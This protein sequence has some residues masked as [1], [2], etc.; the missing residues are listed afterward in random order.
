MEQPSN[1]ELA[2]L[3]EEL[4]QLQESSDQLRLDLT[5]KLAQQE[6]RQKARDPNILSALRTL[7]TD[8]AGYSQGK[9]DFPRESVIGVA[10]AYLRPRIILMFGS[11]IAILIAVGEFWLIYRQNE[12]IDR[13]TEVMRRQ[14]RQ[15][16]AQISASI[17]TELGKAK[18]LYG[19]GQAYFQA[20]GDIAMELVSPIVAYQDPFLI[21][22]PRENETHLTWLNAAMIVARNAATLEPM[23]AHHALTEMFDR[24]S[25]YREAFIARTTPT[26][27]FWLLPVTAKSESPLGPKERFKDD[28]QAMFL[29]TALAHVVMAIDQLMKNR[30]S[31]DI[32][33][34]AT[35]ITEG[36]IDKFAAHIMFLRVGGAGL[37]RVDTPGEGGA[38]DRSIDQFCAAEGRLIT[39]S[40][41]DEIE[42]SLDSLAKVAPDRSQL[43]AITVLLTKNC[44]PYPLSADTIVVQ[45]S[46]RELSLEELDQEEQEIRSDS[47]PLRARAQSAG[48]NLRHEYGDATWQSWRIDPVR[49]CGECQSN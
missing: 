18:S 3:R 10:S 4:R 44:L 32:S 49:P 22:E 21:A 46:W 47:L 2:Q 8:I 20:Y 16:R 23:E 40:T 36:F 6:E 30:S 28:A 42:R 34:V 13:Q 12:I 27:S 11:F 7:V 39:L 33:G 15:T 31:S 25:S 37:S 48:Y 38:L 24:Y 1:D 35:S 5:S 29:D 41:R 45:H 43:A 26:N 17:M 14:E 9:R 19:G